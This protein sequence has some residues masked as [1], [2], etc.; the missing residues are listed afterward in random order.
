MVDL[1]CGLK[2]DGI[3]RPSERGQGWFLATT[4][5]ERAASLTAVQWLAQSELDALA[6]ALVSLAK[7]ASLLGSNFFQDDLASLVDCLERRYVALET[8]FDSYVGIRRLRNA[9]VLLEQDHAQ[10]RFRHA[11]LRDVLYESI[12]AQTKVILH[13][14]ALENAMAAFE[15]GDEDSLQ[16]IAYHA[17]QAGRT[18]AAADAYLRLAEQAKVRQSYLAA[19]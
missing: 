17:S 4:E 5:L 12:D 6:P 8:D 3:V 1:I 19:Q 15:N 7:L 18:Q 13:D 10:C 14:A 16:K 11:L 9:G 2:R